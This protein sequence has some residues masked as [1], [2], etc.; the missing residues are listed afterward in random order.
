M[1]KNCISFPPL[2]DSM[3][4]ARWTGTCW[5]LKKGNIKWQSTGCGLFFWNVVIV[6]SHQS[7]FRRHRGL[8]FDVE[9]HWRFFYFYSSLFLIDFL[10]HRDSAQSQIKEIGH[11]VIW[12]G[13]LQTIRLQYVEQILTCGLFI[14]LLLCDAWNW[15]SLSVSIIRIETDNF[16]QIQ[17]SRALSFFDLVLFW[18]LE[19][20]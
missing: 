1:K 8:Q 5:G 13:R 12:I 3:G 14:R 10:E 16:E 7:R 4:L 15:R 9:N 17:S 6:L 2:V 19:S 11:H 20:C 18:L